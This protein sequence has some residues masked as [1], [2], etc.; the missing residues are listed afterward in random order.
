[1]LRF[2]NKLQKVCS[3]LKTSSISGGILRTAAGGVLVLDAVLLRLRPWVAWAR[4]L[5]PIETVAEEVQWWLRDEQL[6][7]CEHE[8]VPEMPGFYH[9]H[10][11]SLRC[12]SGV[13][14]RNVQ[15]TIEKD[16]GCNHMVCKNTSCRMEFCWICLGPWEPHGS[17]WYN[18][19]R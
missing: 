7:Q 5:P 13:N 17:S 2:R 16:G 8:G 6:D 10:R 12:I 15:V 11:R 9:I 1:M 4:Q 18:C 14:Q 19:N 3:S